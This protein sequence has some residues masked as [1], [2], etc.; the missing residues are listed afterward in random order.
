M[1]TLAERHLAA[2]TR[3]SHLGRV[4]GWG[5]G[6]T[7]WEGGDLGLGQGFPPGIPRGKGALSLETKSGGRERESH[8]RSRPPPPPN[9]DTYLVSVPEGNLDGAPRHDEIQRRTGV[10]PR[11]SATGSLR[12]WLVRG[13]ATALDRVVTAALR[14]R[15]SSGF[16]FPSDA[17]T[18]SS[19]RRPAT[20][21]GPAPCPGS[22]AGQRACRT[23]ILL[24]P[25][26]VLLCS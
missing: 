2:G 18:T 1:R 15:Q 19:G 24:W 12:F 16:S 14:R 17:Q 7:G 23:R 4:Q 20:S 3:G 5:V 13:Q 21:G 26:C 22:T 6:R 9:P 11:R 25:C 8:S 10:L